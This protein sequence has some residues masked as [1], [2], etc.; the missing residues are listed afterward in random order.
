MTLEAMPLGKPIL[1]SKGADIL[2]LVA[3]GENGYVFPLDDATEL[4]NLMQKFLDNPELIQAVG[5]RSQQIM[6]QYRSQA[7]AQCLA[8]VTKVVMSN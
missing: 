7:T 8:E 3:H 5:E 6:A 4:T 1:C 2:E